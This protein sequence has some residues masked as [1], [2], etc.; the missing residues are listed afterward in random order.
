MRSRSSSTRAWTST[1]GEG[2]R[3]EHAVEALGVVEVAGDRPVDA[4]VLDLHRH[5][6]P[7]GHHRP[8][9]LPDRRGGDRHG[10]PLEEEHVGV[11]AELLDHDLLGQA[12]RHRRHVLLELGERGLDLGRHAVGDEADHL[13]E[14]H[15]RALHLPELGG[16]V[17]RGADGELLL[18]RG[19]AG[20]ADRAAPHLGPRPVDAPAGG[21]APDARLAPPAFEAHAA[22]RPPRHA[23]DRRLSRRRARP[24]PT[25]L[26]PSTTQCG[27]R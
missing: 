4:G 25:G 26:V 6:P 7:V 13:A 11:G 9:H 23:T 12:R 3:R 8:V 22:R 20:L 27:W 19:P 15:H 14:L 18:E 24:G 2:E 10:V 21:Q 1:P 5:P 16:D 17:L